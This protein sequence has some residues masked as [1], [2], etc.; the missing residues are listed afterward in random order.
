MLRTTLSRFAALGVTS[1]SSDTHNK[2]VRLINQVCLLVILAIVPHLI[3]TVA[4]GSIFLSWVQLAAILHLW[5]AIAL[6]ARGY[7]GAARIL[8][9]VVGNV[10]I[11][12]MV[13]LLGLEGG[14][15]L[16]YP[17]CLIAP[18]FFY[19]KNESRYYFSFLCFT[20]ILSALNHIGGRYTTPLVDAPESLVSLF[21][22]L[23]LIGSML[24]I[25]SFAFYFYRENSR[26]EVSLV[27]ANKRLLALSETD[28]LTNLPNIRAFRANILREWGAALRGNQRI[29]VLMIDIDNFKV[30][31]DTYGH[32]A[33]DACLTNIAAVIDAKVR[34]HLDYPARYGGEEF[35][36]MMTDM[37]LN[38][39]MSMA[40]RI[41]RSVKE[42]DNV[43]LLDDSFEL[44]CSIG[45]AVTT[46]SEDESVE[47]LISNADKALYDAKNAGKD[48]VKLFN[49]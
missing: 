6:N 13:M 18:L 14:I 16:Y 3:I 8:A 33:G 38:D 25:F 5:L 49:H 42:I 29:A 2:Q 11:F 26:V 10:H 37:T 19:S 45:V 23:S 12:N 39:A 48:C 21:F 17:T 7:F 27:N 1:G 15:Y 4:Y 40:E 47:Y 36:V 32:P 30:L 43:Q 34:K 20:I 31:N 28:E 9:L 46:P 35:I 41:R 24:T 44:T 22:Y